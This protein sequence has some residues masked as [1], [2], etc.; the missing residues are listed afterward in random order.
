MTVKI[1]DKLTE[2]QIKEYQR[3]HKNDFGED[4]STE[5]AEENGLNLIRVIATIINALEK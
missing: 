3:I 4:L 2:E 1:P 5:E